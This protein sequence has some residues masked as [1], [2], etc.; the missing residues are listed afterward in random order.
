MQVYDLPRATYPIRH[1]GTMLDM[2]EHEGWVFE[3]RA[4]RCCEL[5]ASSTWHR[6]PSHPS[7]QPISNAP[8]AL[9]GVQGPAAAGPPPGDGLPPAALRCRCGVPPN[10]TLP[11]E[12]TYQAVLQIVD[13]L[14]MTMPLVAKSV[15]AD[16]RE[17][18]HAL[19]V[20]NTV[21]G[22]RQL[23]E[24]PPPPGG[25][26]PP[27]LLEQYV[28][29]GGCLFKVYVLADRALRVKRASLQLPPRP[30]APPPE[31]QPG[32]RRPQQQATPLPQPAQQPAPQPL[33]ASSP[34]QPAGNGGTPPPAALP[35][36][37]QEV[38]PA[39]GEPA[40]LEGRPDLEF[41]ERVSAYPR[42]KSWGKADLAPKVCGEALAHD[43]S[44]GSLPLAGSR[45][46]SGL[47]GMCSSRS[48][49]SNAGHAWE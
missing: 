5:M 1:R 21:E 29:H 13:E 49:H 8:L 14:G 7:H 11:E 40:P 35:S 9:R 12:V 27:C 30:Q 41:V 45:L 43:I 33:Q 37:G 48:E 28:D 24:C 19:A 3:V 15:W 44:A 18:S 32:Q 26:G 22:L 42:A 10:T 6:H 38:S 47:D 36:G 17:G 16:G 4:C 39:Q 31:Q 46:P 2:V 34:Q 20:V 25:F 23:V